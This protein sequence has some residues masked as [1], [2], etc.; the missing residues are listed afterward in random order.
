MHDR[1]VLGPA[2]VTDDVL[3]GMV[4]HCQG[5]DEVELLSSHADIAPYDLEALTTGGRFWVQGRARLGRDEVPYRLFVK[6]VQS[7][8][9]SPLF[10]LVPES[11][12]EAALDMLPWRTEPNVYRSDLD[13]R[14]PDG[15]ALPLCLG[16]CD[17]D[18]ESAAIWLMDVQPQPV[19]WD[20]ARHERAAYLLGRMAASPAVRTVAEATSTRGT[21][22]RGYADG[23]LAHMVIPALLDEEI[24]QHPLVAAFDG[25]LRDDLRA[26]ALAVGDVVDELDTLPV[27][28]AH[29]DACTRNLLVVDGDDGF[30]LIDFGFWG[31]AP[32]GHDLAQLLLGEV[33]MGERPAAGLLALEDSCLAAYVRGLHD[34]GHDAPIDVVRR[35]HALTMLLFSGLSAIP[36][37]HLG[38]DPTPQL[39]RVAR[40]RAASARFILDLCASTALVSG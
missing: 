16:V 24:W 35:S 31:Q 26:A 18:D 27:A 12:R 1:S 21:S 15:L 8:R 19:V 2:E 39:L 5:V 13:A 32:V 34:E 40:E 38:A 7:W 30:V 22:V 20:A 14:L 17:L 4:A 11:L 29:G 36:L 25:R 6:V 3:A 10:A 23:R 33:Q 28:V 37:E 9:R